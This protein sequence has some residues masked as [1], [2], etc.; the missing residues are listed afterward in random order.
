MIEQEEVFFSEEESLQLITKM[1]S[2]AKEDF[3]ETGISALMWGSIV[4][5]CAL[6][7]FASNYI[8][9]RG[10]EYIW[11]LTI[12]AFIPQVIISVRENKRK[13][14]KAYH[15]DAMGGIWIAFAISM[16]L[17]GFYF[18][19]LSSE[20]IVYEHL[21]SEILYL[22]IYGIPT[23]ATGIARRF[24]PMIFGG[25]ACWVLAIASAFV[26]YPFTMLLVAG[27]ALVAWFIPGLL[28]QRRYIN[29]KKGQH[30]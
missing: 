26:S 8:R 15:E 21:H 10:V 3:V 28:L 22:V 25:I 1:I 4:T 19:F 23:F 24:K 11:F 18:S 14:F 12:L 9:I 7:E 13:K 20:G 30:V 2:K 5:F 27:G 16:F 17:I 6:V 29:A